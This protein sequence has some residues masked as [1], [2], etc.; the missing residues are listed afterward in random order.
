LHGREK[1]AGPEE[2]EGG[3]DVIRSMQYLDGEDLKGLLTMGE[4][5]GCVEEA[6]RFHSSGGA[7]LWPVISA[8]FE[9]GVRDM[10]I[11]SGAIPGRGIYGLK[12]VG[13]AADNPEERGIPA[14]AG[15][16]VVMSIETGHP[17]GIADGRAITEL[18]TGAAGAVGAKALARPDSRRALVLGAGSQGRAQ[19]EGLA[20][21]LPLEYLA[22]SCPDE[23]MSRCCAAEMGARFPKLILEALPWD[24]VPEVAGTSDV[25]VT[26]TP[27][28]RPILRSE[29]VRPGTHINAVGADMP[30][31][32]EVEAA[33]LGRARVFADARAQVVSRG[34]CHH[35]LEA[36]ILS[37][38]D[39]VEIGEV[40][41]G[42]VPGRLSDEEITLFDATGI[43]LQD[44]LTAD[45]ALRKARETGAGRELPL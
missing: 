39:I 45:L 22:V 24:R 11:K 37:P 32:Q 21:V 7:E 9:P 1:S 30:E 42:R 38:E 18:R 19:I 35:A 44:L 20:T 27:S 40:L 6:Y 4:V 33:L 3:I 28:E 2:S 13:Y 14:V 10:D 16:V 26:C 15:L 5:L 25:I 31:K 41:S 12:V 36:G 29:W 8:V 23:D 34:E 17:L 43:A